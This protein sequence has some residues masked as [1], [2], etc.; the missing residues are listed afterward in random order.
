MRAEFHG[1]SWCFID[2]VLGNVRFDQALMD[3]TWV[4]PGAV[5]GYVKAVHG[6]DLGEMPKMGGPS[7]RAR[8][9]RSLPQLGNHQDLFG[10]RYGRLR[11][12]ADGT[13]EAAGQNG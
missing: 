3:A 7:Q 1:N 4:G 8:G 13:T 5:E 2:E 6:L 9:V 11:L 10:G 12:N